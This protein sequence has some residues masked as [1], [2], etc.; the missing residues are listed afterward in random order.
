[1]VERL[2]GTEGVAGG[3]L[4]GGRHLQEY[5]GFALWWL[6]VEAEGL[7]GSARSSGVGWWRWMDGGGPAR[8]E[9]SRRVAAVELA[10]GEEEGFPPLLAGRGAH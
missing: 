9:L 10:E 1:M 5:W 6:S 3:E 4:R 2:A 8:N 7:G